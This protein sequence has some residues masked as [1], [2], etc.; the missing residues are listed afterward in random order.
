MREL[1][2]H[3]WRNVFGAGCSS[4]PA[5]AG[6]SGH[7][8]DDVSVPEESTGKGNSTMIWPDLSE[9]GL[10]EVCART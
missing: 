1:N 10:Q 7:E 5:R 4:E 8:Y 9:E 3:K 6:P 2:V